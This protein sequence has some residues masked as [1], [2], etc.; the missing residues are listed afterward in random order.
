MMSSLSRFPL[1]ANQTAFKTVHLFDSA[2]PLHLTTQA[3]LLRAT[4]STNTIASRSS[5]NLQL[6]L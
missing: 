3:A 6:A 2:L 4:C 1:T 5:K